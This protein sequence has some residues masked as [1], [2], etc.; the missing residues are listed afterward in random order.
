MMTIIKKGEFYTRYQI[1]C[2][3][4]L[5]VLEGTDGDFWEDSSLTTTMHYH[6]PVCKADKSVSTYYNPNWRSMIRYAINEDGS[7]GERLD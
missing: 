7:I 1:K 5:S 4:C 2:P 6:C 3:D